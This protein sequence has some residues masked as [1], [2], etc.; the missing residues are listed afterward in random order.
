MAYGEIEVYITFAALFGKRLEF[1]S[2][3]KKLVEED[4]ARKKRYTVF[5]LLRDL[6]ISS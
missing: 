3:N 6:L 2:K 4:D 1:Q 5:A